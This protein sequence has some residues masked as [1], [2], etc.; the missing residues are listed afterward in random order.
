MQRF[1]PIAVAVMFILVAGSA[2]AATM[3]S[4]PTA[5][6][7][8][9]EDIA[10]YGT[11][12]TTGWPTEDKWWA[13]RAD[14][15]GTP[16]K[17]CGQTFTTGSA[18]VI[19]NAFTFQIKH[20]TEPTK[21]Y[22]IRVGEVSGTTFTEIAS[23]SATQSAATAADDYWTWT[24]DSPVTLSANTAYG[25][26]VGLLSSTSGW[27]T[28]IPYMYRTADEYPGGSRF[29]SG[30]EGYGVGNDTMDQMS[31]DRVFHLD[32]V[33][34]VVPV[35]DADTLTPDAQ[36]GDGLWRNG[37][38]NWWDADGAENVPWDDTK[39]YVAIFGSGNATADPLVTVDTVIVAGG[40]VFND[41]NGYTYT[42]SAG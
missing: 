13:D 24:L 32:L 7:I 39:Q 40:I 22:A 26:D 8:D 41:A 11:P 34:D 23:E 20:A 38:S 37:Q 10:S 15:F 36:D 3:T 4:S 17:T 42:L 12:T 16:G 21:E 9:G 6:T 25:V 29:R 27:Q 5:P 33:P 31:A 2:H 28:G 30:T 35:W 19:L 18:A 14:T 1:A